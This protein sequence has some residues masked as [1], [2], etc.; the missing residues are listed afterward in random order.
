MTERSL[1]PVSPTPPAAVARWVAIALLA[2]GAALR[3]IQYFGRASYWLDELPLARMIE[4]FSM[5]RLLTQP[6]KFQ[7]SVPPALLAIEKL[8]QSAFGAGEYSLRFVPLAA[9]L[10]TLVLLRRLLGRLEL[11][12]AGIV[13]GCALAAFSPGLIFYGAELRQYSTDVCCAAALAL[14]AVGDLHRKSPGASLFAAAAAAPWI[15]NQSVFV[16]CGIA[17]VFAAGAA[18]RRFRNSGRTIAFVLVAL[19]SA[20]AATLVARALISPGTM[21]YFREFWIAGFPP[22]PLRFGS[23][24]RWLVDAFT[25]FWTIFLQFPLPKV[26]LSLF[27]AGVVSRIRKPGVLAI[28]LLPGVAALAAASSRLYPFEQ[29]SIA[30]LAPATIV[31]CAAS[32][33]W[34]A[35]AGR[36]TG[37]AT[38][39]LGAAVVFALAA[40]AL[41]R[42]H[43]FAERQ[44]TRELLVELARIRRPGDAIFVDSGARQAFGFYGPRA[45]LS[46]EGV[47]PG[48]C[49]APSPEK[50]E[51]ALAPLEGR[52]RVWLF[53]SDLL[54]THQFDEL[55]DGYLPGRGR[56]LFTLVGEP[57]HPNTR[58][59]LLDLSGAPQPRRP[60]RRPAAQVVHRHKW[61]VGGPQVPDPEFVP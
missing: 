40:V 12:A 31:L 7:Q 19:A 55:L 21:A 39:A 2:A 49:T 27:V 61:C 26:G 53:L 51:K 23:V 44:A 5:A 47:T 18:R 4:S 57:R 41:A 28:L 24:R 48:P 9:S 14:L 16:V 35:R 37:P 34:L 42:H 15:S 32:L 13:A 58:I 52:P 60:P 30:F 50:F 43:P 20:A 1:E 10:A 38:A 45:G 36:R 56:R 33:D 3:L 17:A 25:G 54:P 11:S 46:L 6:L 8:M 59:I 22:R 29:R